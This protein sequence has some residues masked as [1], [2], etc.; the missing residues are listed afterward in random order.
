MK[1]MSKYYDEKFYEQKVVHSWKSAKEIIP[2]LLELIRPK[3]V[4]D[5]GCGAGIW[6]ASFKQHGVEDFVGVDGEWVKQTTLQIPKEQFIPFDLTKLFRLN[7]EFDLVMSLEVAE[8]ISEEFSDTLI[9]TLVSLGPVVLFS[10]AIPFQGGAHHVNEQ[11]PNYWAKKFLKRGYVTVDCIRKKVWSNDDVEPFYAQNMLIFVRKTALERNELLKKEFENTTD[12][13]LSLV[14]PK[15][16]LSRTSEP[17][18]ARNF[19]E[20]LLQFVQKL[21]VQ[22]KRKI[23]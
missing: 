10:A 9:D 6:L 11:W 20:L 23:F 14:H 2:L 7:R 18:R 16:W 19:F 4:I 13:Q 15:L 5:I 17:M 21:I 1:N 8:H 12:A 22:I 3:S